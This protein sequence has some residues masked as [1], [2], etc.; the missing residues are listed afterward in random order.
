MIRSIFVCWL[1]CLSLEFFTHTKTSTLLVKY[2]KFWSTCMLGDHDHFVSIESTI[3]HATIS[4]IISED[5]SHSHFVEHLATELSLPFQW[6]SSVA[7]EI[8]TS[9]LS[10]EINKLKMHVQVTLNVGNNR[11]IDHKKVLDW[12]LRTTRSNETLRSNW[13]KSLLKDEDYS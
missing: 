5:P 13:H 2:W 4:K 12:S 1:F 9:N 11:L 3:C 6:I 8:R 10:H 7:T